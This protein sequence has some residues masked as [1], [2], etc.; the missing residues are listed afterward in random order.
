VSYQTLDVPGAVN[1]FWAGG[2]N[3][4]GQVTLQWNTGTGSAQSSVYDGSTYTTL[5]V[6]GATSTFA[7]AINNAGTV[8]LWSEASQINGAVGFLK[9]G[10]YYYAPVAIPNAVGNTSYSYGINNHSVVV[11]SYESSKTFQ[12]LGFLAKPGVA[13]QK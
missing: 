4:S 11:G 6:P 2:I 5:E 7:G 13:R 10:K 9:N 8:A 3:D 12:V 1:T